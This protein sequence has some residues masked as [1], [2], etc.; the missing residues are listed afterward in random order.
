MTASTD[1]ELA[2]CHRSTL[3]HGFAQV[4]EEITKDPDHGWKIF[5]RFDRLTTRNLLYLQAKLSSLEAKQI[6]YDQEVLLS[7]DIDSKTA[8]TSW[9]DFQRLA[10]ADGHDR[11]KKGMSL[12]R[13]I[14]QTLETYH[15]ALKRYSRILDLPKPAP[16]TL[17]A[18]KR[19]RASSRGTLRKESSTVL[20]DEDDLVGLVAPASQ[21]RL[22]TFILERFAWLFVTSQTTPQGTAYVR[23]KTL[24]RIVTLLS[25]LL[26][27]V[28]L[29][30]AVVSLNYAPNQNIRL[31][32]VAVF[33]IAFA[34]TVALL[35]SAGRSEVFV[36]TAAY[37]AVLVV[38]IGGTAPTYSKTQNG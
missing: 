29:I 18:L 9:E 30:G 12:A 20:D 19:F 33:T 2:K 36:A 8:A 11:E 1:I 16:T 28:L 14:E 5:K 24:A 21:D 6:A 22:T 15:S 23:A 25:T 13:E 37:A 10:E 26:A 32:L 34:G 27:A 3:P 31:A 17:K 4:T 7:G 38:F 35:S